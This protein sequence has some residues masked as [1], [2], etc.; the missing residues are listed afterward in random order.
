MSQPPRKRPAGLGRGLSAL[1]GEAVREEP[2][3]AEGARSPG[4]R[5]VSV[6][7]LEPHP[8]Q[9]RRHFDEDAL[10]ELAQSIK[11]RGMIQP[12]VVRPHRGG[13]QIVAGERRWRAAQRARL[14]SVPVIVHDFDEAETL[15]LALVE[16]IQRE[17]LNAIEEAEAYRKLIDRF[18]HSQEALGRIVHKSRSHI[19]NLLRLLDLPATVRAML[20]EGSMSMGHA[21]ALITAPDPEALARQVVDHGLSVRSTEKLAQAARPAAL[22]T[23]REEKSGNADIQALERQLGDIL[24]L[25]VS[26]SYGTAGAGTVTIAYSSLDQLDLI[27]QRL[28]GERI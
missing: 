26:I 22:K 3:T 27:C 14:H 15:E 16:N 13:Y 12:I 17:D 11:A 2:V 6:A 18:G 7:D 5:T 19:A 21:R 20:A 10:D 1:L 28:T 23:S 4:V 9:P 24:G 25:K 8:E